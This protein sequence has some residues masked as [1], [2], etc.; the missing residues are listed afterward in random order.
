MNWNIYRNLDNHKKDVPK[1]YAMRFDPMQF[2]PADLE[3]E[4]EALSSVDKIFYTNHAEERIQQRDMVAFKR[5][6]MQGMDSR[7]LDMRLSRHKNHNADVG[8]DILPMVQQVEATYNPI[9]GKNEILRINFRCKNAL[10]GRE[11]GGSFDNQDAVF[12]MDVKKDKKGRNCGIMMTGWMCDSNDY[13][14]EAQHQ[15]T[16]RKMLEKVQAQ[17]MKDYRRDNAPKNA[18]QKDEPDPVR[19][20]FRSGKPKRHNHHKPNHSHKPK[21]NFKGKKKEGYK[22]GRKSDYG[23]FNF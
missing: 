9:S 5:L 10:E 2:L 17:I 19:E 1:N 13:N 23:D 20:A 8:K 11:D 7:D 22:R 15:Y 6:N 4:L 16:N 21:Q 18:Y 14:Y 12:V 3:E